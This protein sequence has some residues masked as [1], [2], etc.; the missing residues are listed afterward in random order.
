MPISD[1][2]PE[3]HSDIVALSCSQV[4]SPSELPTARVLSLVSSYWSLIAR[5]FRYHSLRVAGEN[6]I[7]KLLRH[8]DRLPEC[9]RRVRYFSLSD[10][11]QYSDEIAAY[12]RKSDISRLL[13]LVA[14]FLFMLELHLGDPAYATALFAF[15]WQCRC[16]HLVSLS[17]RGYYCFAVSLS[18]PSD[19]KS[20]KLNFPRLEHLSLD[21]IPNP[22]GLLNHGI[23]ANTFPRLASLEIH[24]LRGALSFAREVA[25]AVAERDESSEC[26]ITKEKAT[27][28][29]SRLP[30]TL[31][32]LSLFPSPP[33]SAK[34]SKRARILHDGM[35]DVLSRLTK[36][37]MWEAR[38]DSNLQV[39]I[40]N[41]DT[42]IVSHSF[43]S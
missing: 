17:I 35:M 7:A 38:V 33:I 13:A 30:R 24:G 18:N 19:V 36:R 9:E 39:V 16:P 2:P 43:R 14:P 32:S 41:S 1:L 28:L 3:L 37:D 5:P 31:H 15:F 22:S 34:N 23:L 4:L 8:L 21:G 26:T 10:S 20:S 29:T 12:Q 27:V 6:G 25:E 40:G 42:D 11:L